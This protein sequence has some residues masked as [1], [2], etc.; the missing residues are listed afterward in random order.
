MMTTPVPSQ[1]PQDEAEKPL[2]HTTGNE[3]KIVGTVSVTGSIPKPLRIDMSADSVCM[4]LVSQ[5]ETGWVII[6]GNRLKNAFVYL[7]GEPLQNYR[8]EV[9]SWEV[10]LQHNQCQ[11]FPHVTGLQVGQPLQIMNVDPTVHNTHPTPKVNQEWNFS[12]PPNSPAFVKTFARPEVVI[13][14]KCNQHPWERA[15]VGVFKHP[16]FA[17][18]DGSGMFEIRNVPPGTYKLVV[19]HEKLGE[20]EQDLT[21]LAGETRTADFTLNAP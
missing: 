13:P 8:F 5:P 19:W 9:P 12:Q 11:Y 6:N 4:E 20:Q 15:Y 2:Y 1:K 18:S 21:L 14:F 7:K 3:A 16:Y 10:T 17:I